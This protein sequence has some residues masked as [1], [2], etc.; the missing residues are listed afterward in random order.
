MNQNT[1]VKIL[2]VCTLPCSEKHPLIFACYEQLAEGEAFIL[3]NDHDPVP[4]HDKFEALYPAAYAWEYLE[5]GPAFWRIKITKL[6]SQP[7]TG[8]DVPAACACGG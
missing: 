4:L 3:R 6:R 5:R 2:D 7:K 8:A 1:K